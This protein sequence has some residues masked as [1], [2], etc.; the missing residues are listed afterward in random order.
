MKLIK[1]VSKHFPFKGYIALIF[2]P[3]VFIREDLKDKFDDRVEAHELIHAAQQQE[4]L[5]ILFFLIYSLEYLI[6]LPLCGFNH[7]RAYKSVSFEQEAYN[8]DNALG[9]I[10]FRVPLYWVR[11][12][13]T[14]KK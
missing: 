4:T 12:I 11:Y 1:V 10:H 8:Y 3:W 2:C 9:Y 5:W 13:F 14:I 6:K 7:T